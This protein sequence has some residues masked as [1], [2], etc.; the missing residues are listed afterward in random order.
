MW[1][2]VAWL[3][4]CGTKDDG[5]PGGGSALCN[6][7]ADGDGFG[8]TT[9]VAASSCTDDGVADN[10]DD[11]D[12]EASSIHP[13][14]TETAADGIDQD[15]D[16]DDLCFEDLDADTYGGV[17]R[18]DPSCAAAGLIGR[19]GDCDDGDAAVHPGVDE[20]PGDAID[21]DCDGGEICYADSDGDGFGTSIQLASVDIDCA[22][23]GEADNPDDC[24]DAGVDGPAT[25]PGAAE[26][27]SGSACM[28][29]AD[30]D[31]YGSSSPAKGVTP[32]SDCNDVDEN[33]H[34]PEFHVGNDE[35]FPEASAHSADYL[36]GSRL[37]VKTPMT[38]TDLALIGKAPGA[39]VRMALYT[40]ANGPDALVV[41]GPGTAMVA[42]VLEMAV[43]PT[44]I[45]AGNYWIMA[46][47]NAAASVGVEYGGEHYYKYRPL[48][49]SDPMPDPFG[50]ITTEEGGVSNYYIVGY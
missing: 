48:L 8:T 15:C 49:F 35:E 34:C 22:D 12:D 40:D 39:R 11:C 31:G 24:L 47:Y 32:G 1:F 20:V 7:D 18:L 27:E 38:V 4:G 14:A 9:T 10:A 42:G 36:L 17:L 2:L 5:S 16:G 6:V 3:P 41:E 28:T 19:D 25:F 30:G 29:D 13:G 46:I 21:Q 43:D 37:D 33:S 26:Y 45:E 44:P 50:T 23:E